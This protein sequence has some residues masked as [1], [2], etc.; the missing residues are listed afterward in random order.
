MYSNALQTTKIRKL[1]KRFKRDV[2]AENFSNNPVN[3]K[4]L[5][6]NEQKEEYSS[7][8]IAVVQLAG[9]IECVISSN[10]SQCEKS[11]LEYFSAQIGDYFKHDHLFPEIAQ[12]FS[13]YQKKDIKNIRV[14]FNNLKLSI[15]VDDDEIEKIV[16]SG[17]SVIDNSGKC[18]KTHVCVDRIHNVYDNYFRKNLGLQETVLELWDSGEN[19]DNDNLLK[20]REAYTSYLGRRIEKGEVPRH[21]LSTI[22][23]TYDDDDGKPHVLTVE[24]PANMYSN[25]F[26]IKCN[27]NIKTHCNTQKN[28]SIFFGAIYSVF[29][30][31]DLHV[32][33]RWMLSL[34]LGDSLDLSDID[35]CMTKIRERVNSVRIT[36]DDFLNESV[37]SQRAKGFTKFNLSA[38]A[39]I[40]IIINKKIISLFPLKGVFSLPQ[41]G[42]WENIEKYFDEIDQACKDYL[43]SFLKPVVIEMRYGY[44]K[45][46]GFFV[47]GLK[48][49]KNNYKKFKKFLE[50]LFDHPQQAMEILNRLDNVYKINN[51]TERREQLTDLINNLPISA[52]DPFC[53]YLNSCSVGIQESFQRLMKDYGLIDNDGNYRFE[54]YDNMPG[55]VFPSIRR[56]G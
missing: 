50:S 37:V 56:N 6:V 25:N 27:G 14:E 44:E 33:G 28:K 55:T 49:S 4:A 48:N 42:K 32:S 52:R 31:V 38:D 24:I 39:M 15:K 40:E 16:L 13:E 1:D 29:R 20:E 9:S 12:S 19:K 23:M 5:N 21:I 47:D 51:P 30:P 53:Q 36:V 17:S 54:S 41:S 34:E 46:P 18:D 45:A 35:E 10:V 3:F 8:A 7:K 11:D 2:S 22:F 26:H 43:E